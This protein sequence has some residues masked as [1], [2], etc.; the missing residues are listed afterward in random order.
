MNVRSAASLV[1]AAVAG[2]PS[3]VVVGTASRTAGA[4]ICALA[5]PPG[6]ATWASDDRVLAM[7]ESGALAECKLV[8]LE[9]G[10]REDLDAAAAAR[11]S[12][13]PALV[14][15]IPAHR[16]DLR[17]VAERLG[18]D[19][20]LSSPL[21]LEEAAGLAKALLSGERD[22][23]VESDR[24]EPAV[25]AVDLR[26]LHDLA[27]LGGKEFVH[28]IV[29]QF[30][31]DAATLLRT[32]HDAMA[33][34]DAQ[35]FRDQAHAL[36]SC[37]ANVGASSVYARCLALRGIER[38]ELLEQGPSHL[39]RLECEVSSAREALQDFVATG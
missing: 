38:R 28:D 3:P 13:R 8:I 18:F 2:A 34:G 1:E 27:G 10:R 5:G 29:A 26:A 7:F 12:A 15:F 37:A 39:E 30:V 6:T 9:I 20:C 25:Q 14:A 19:G 11:N 36:R 4:V 24:D 23:A 16:A 35:T 32:L 33:R 17:K 22:D 21:D 31:D